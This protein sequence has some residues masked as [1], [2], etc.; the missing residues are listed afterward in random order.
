M[1]SSLVKYSTPVLV[2]VAA[3]KPDQKSKK[4]HNLPPLEKGIKDS[5]LRIEDILNQIIPPK[6]FVDENGQLKVQTVLSTPA[7]T[8]EISTLKN[9]LERKLQQNQARETGICPIR[10]EL[11]D[12]CFDELIRQITIDCKQR[13]ILLVNVI[14][15]SF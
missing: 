10:E 13:G 1:H 6:E 15:H 8:I 2:S 11:Y 12:Q 14:I 3:K 4:D 5:S 9:E 7:K